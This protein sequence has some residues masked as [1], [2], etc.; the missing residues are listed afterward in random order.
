M[1]D[2]YKNEMSGS[3]RP[4][5]PPSFPSFPSFPGSHQ[6]SFPLRFLNPVTP[7]IPPILT[8]ICG[9]FVLGIIYAGAHTGIGLPF[10]TDTPF[11]G[12]EPILPSDE[13]AEDPAPP[14]SKQEL[15]NFIYDM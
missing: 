3:G 4:P 15:F 9:G 13:P 14:V 1:I 6:Q 8:F 11:G 2:M 7:G 5:S 10:S 12:E